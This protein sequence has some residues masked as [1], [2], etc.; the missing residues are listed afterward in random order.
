MRSGVQRL[1][2]RSGL[3]KLNQC[4]PWCIS[5]SVNLKAGLTVGQL[6]LSPSSS[7]FA[8]DKVSFKTNPAPEVRVRDESTQYSLLN[9][10]CRSLAEI[11]DRL[12]SRHD[13]NTSSIALPNVLASSER[14]ATCNSL[15]VEFLFGV[16]WKARI[17]AT[18]FS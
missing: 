14:A 18:A 8:F 1:R 13:I 6:W 16:C 10:A 7:R 5:F 4:C 15:V 12:P 2:S 17:A 3:G 9:S 11:S